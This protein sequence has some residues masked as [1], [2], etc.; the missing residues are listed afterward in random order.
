MGPLAGQPS[1]AGLR[2]LIVDDEADVRQLVTLMLQRN[3]AEIM[4]AGSTHE[5]VQMMASWKP[6]VLVADIGMPM[7]DGYALIRRVR[8]HPSNEGGL[9]PA[10]ALTAYARPEDRVRILSSGYHMHLAKPVEPV[11]LIAAVAS[12]AGRRNDYQT[13]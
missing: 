10:L 5:A 3:G 4:G 6:D 9:T 1:L 13:G 7:E 2:V 11:E 8:S 12:L